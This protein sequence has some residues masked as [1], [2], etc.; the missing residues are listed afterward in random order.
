MPAKKQPVE[1]QEAKQKKTAQRNVDMFISRLLKYNI[2][3]NLSHFK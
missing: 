1:E 2:T 3:G